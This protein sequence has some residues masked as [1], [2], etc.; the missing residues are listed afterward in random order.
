VNHKRLSVSLVIPAYNEERHLAACLESIAAQTVP[1]KRVIV[2]DNNSTDHTPELA[3]KYP[4]V[5]VLQE[6]KQGIVFARNK[7]FNAVTSEIIGRIDADSVLPPNWVEYVQAFFSD[8]GNDWTAWTGGPYFYNVRFPHLVSGI[9]S[10]LS[11]RCNRFL[12]GNYTLWGSNM[13]VRSSD[14]QTVRG[15]ICLRNDIHED[16]DLAIHLHHTGVN[17][18]YDT[19][20]TVHTQLRRVRTN[21]HELWAYLQWWPRTLRIHQKKTW[22]I[23]WFF[24]AF[25][26]YYLT[27]L[28]N[29]AEYVARLAGKKPLAED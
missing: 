6:K 7:G 14:W 8:P 2:V 21:R 5:T 27:P 29:L 1:P 25:L 13:A 15:S 28:L 26:L 3:R 24:G 9:Y 10:F 12:A 18:V 4:F 19:R 11:F 16:L 22:V 17:I 23:C 20:L